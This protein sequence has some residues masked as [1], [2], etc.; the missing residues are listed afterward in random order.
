LRIESTLI[1]A[2][3]SGLAT[4]VPISKSNTSDHSCDIA[5]D[6]SGTFDRN[7]GRARVLRAVFEGQNG[8]SAAAETLCRGQVP[9]V[10]LYMDGQHVAHAAPMASSRVFVSRGLDDVLARAIT[11]IVAFI[12]RYSLNLAEDFT[13]ETKRTIRRQPDHSPRLALSY[14]TSTLPRLAA[15]MLRRLRYYPA[16][17]RVGYRFVDGPGVAEK[18]SL[19]GEPWVVLPDPGDRF[20][21]DPFPFKWGDN[22][23]IFVEELVHS[24]GKGVISVSECGPNGVFGVPKPVLEKPY[25]L[26]Y[27]QVFEYDGEVWMMP[28]SAEGRKLCLY[29]ADRFPDKWVEEHVLI[30]DRE[31][32]DATLLALGGKYWLFASERDGAGNSS[33][34]MVVFFA[35]SLKGPWRPHKMNP[36]IIDKTAARPGGGF[37]KVVD[38][39][40]LPL[41]DGTVCYGGGLG[42]AELIRLDTDRVELRRPIPIETAG[43]WVY[44]RIHTVNRA[45]RLEVIDGIAQVPL[46][47]RKSSR[48]PDI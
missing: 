4:A 17:F 22:Y 48:P 25:H 13:P 30:A 19:A 28:E 33:D 9:V 42:Y 45:G 6:L 27:P 14:V 38:R 46:A 37:A 5:I 8:L 32:V 47:R 36:I 10:D 31:I 7:K 29:R 26:S 12:D 39:I 21:A 2:K 11:L 18:G 40:L 44:P 3:E 20:Y 34:T 43:F 23:Y 41:Q 35:E 16:H 24:R 1:R 15:R